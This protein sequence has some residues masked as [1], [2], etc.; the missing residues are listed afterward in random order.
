M[1]L[2]FRS[3][4]EFLKVVDQPRNAIVIDYLLDDETRTIQRIVRIECKDKELL[5]MLEA[6]GGHI[7]ASGII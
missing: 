7:L 5:P 2:I 4:V 3:G 1:E 6:T